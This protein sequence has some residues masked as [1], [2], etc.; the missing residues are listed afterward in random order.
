MQ[1]RRRWNR[2]PTRSSI[3][4]SIDKS[5]RADVQRPVRRS[6]D[7]RFAAGVADGDGPSRTRGDAVSKSRQQNQCTERNC[8]RRVTADARSNC[9]VVKKTRAR[10]PHIAWRIV[11]LTHLFTRA[12]Y[13]STAAKVASARQTCRRWRARRGCRVRICSRRICAADDSPAILRADS[14]RL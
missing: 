3:S 2:R 8:E 9:Q 11:R 5:E 4:R 6:G 1:F 12:A 14:R 7:Q 13:N 10:E